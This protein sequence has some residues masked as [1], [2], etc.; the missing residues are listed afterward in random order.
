MLPDPNLNTAHWLMDATPTPGATLARPFTDVEID[1][2]PDADRLW[3]T[4]LSLTNAVDDAVDRGIDA[5]RKVWDEEHE[6]ALDHVEEDAT[7]EGRMQERALIADAL[8][9]LR[10]TIEAD[11]VEGTLRADFRWP[12]GTPEETATAIDAATVR[13]I[14]AVLEAVQPHVVVKVPW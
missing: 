6:G 8:A 3:A 14:D 12:V 9:G 10:V 13:A 7:R 1:A 2:H 5:E 11:P 4:I